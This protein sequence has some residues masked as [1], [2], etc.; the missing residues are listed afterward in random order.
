MKDY[1]G[2]ELMK[3]ESFSFSY[4]TDKTVGWSIN[5]CQVGNINLISGKNSSG[6]TRFVK[7]IYTLSNLIL[8]EDKNFHKDS[9][10]EWKIRLVDDDVS[11]DYAL[12]VSDGVV[13][14]EAMI[15]NGETVIERD[16]EGS[17]II[18]FIQL[19]QTI[20][21]ST[22][23]E[24]LAVYKRDKLQHPFLEFLYDWCDNLYLYRFGEDLGRKSL[25][26]IMNHDELS[27][28]QLKK[29]EKKDIAVLNKFDMGVSRLGDDFKN[30]IIESFNNLGYS[31]TDVMVKPYEVRGIS[32]PAN[33]LYVE[34]NGSL[35]EQGDISQGMFRAL[36][37]IIQ[38]T[39]LE[40]SSDS[41]TTILIDDIGEGLD[42]ERSVRLIK[43]VIEKSSELD[44]RLQVVMTTNDR[45]V[46]N[47]IPI[48]YWI[49][50]EKSDDGGISTYS[51]ITNEKE[52]NEFR[53]YGLNNFE[54]LTDEYYKPYDE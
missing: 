13:E 2:G 24:K 14:K 41:K 39:Y 33:I 4:K 31:I 47:N 20:S 19:K 10:S 15:F 36:S 23:K 37:L 35:I 11:I 1:K 17:G 5:D 27:G 34:E 7:A 12:N 46:M 54:F 30:K 28:D 48:K 29:L 51:K 45:M 16:S 18:K 25:S 32:H 38:L 43:Y 9:T 53:H 6:K 26:P 44:G 8:N 22:P 52:F 42:F 21:F 49:V 40:L 50:M 3:I